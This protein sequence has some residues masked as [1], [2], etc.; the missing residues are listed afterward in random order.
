MD[1]ILKSRG[2]GKTY[3]L[4][5]RS[6][7]T[8]ERILC[9]TI[10]SARYIN[11]KAREMGVNIP[12]AMFY[13]HYDPERFNDKGVMIDELSSLLRTLLNCKVNAVTDTPDNILV[14]TND[15]S[16]RCSMNMNPITYVENLTTN[17]EYSDL[18]ANSIAET[19]GKAIMEK[20]SS[21]S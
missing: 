3:D 4:I 1:Y 18:L 11:S 5:Q 16:D 6:A 14:D 20:I 19:V 7:K 9:S 15:L 8:G 13:R 10:T 21:K 12:E 17:I 2:R